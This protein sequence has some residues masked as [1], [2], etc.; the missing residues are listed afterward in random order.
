MIRA[1]SLWVLLNVQTRRPVRIP[2]ELAAAYG[3]TSERTV[4]DSFENLPSIEAGCHKLCNELNIRRSDIDTFNHV[5]NTKYLEWIMEAIPQEIYEGFNLTSFE[6]TYKKET[7]INSHIAIISQIIS[8]DEKCCELIHSI[9][10]T[11]SNNESA[12]SRTVWT[13]I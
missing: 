13:V 3:S 4:E 11:D 10:N 6:I 2:T 5:N 12:S 9:V 7:G 8:K 1:T